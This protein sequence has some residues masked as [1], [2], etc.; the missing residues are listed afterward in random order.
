MRARHVR[1]EDGLRWR[2]GFE[3]NL[4]ADGKEP[5]KGVGIQQPH[6]VVPYAHGFRDTA[7][8]DRPTSIHRATALSAFSVS[9]KQP[10]SV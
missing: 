7:G 4:P 1:C 2:E 5:S 10:G 3:K 8:R 9:G 6:R